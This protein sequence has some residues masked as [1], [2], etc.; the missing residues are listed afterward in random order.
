MVQNKAKIQVSK[1]GQYTVTIPKSL[2]HA[3]GYKQGQEVE[4][5]VAGAGRLELLVPK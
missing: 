5:R 3:M 1:I 4:F 2:A